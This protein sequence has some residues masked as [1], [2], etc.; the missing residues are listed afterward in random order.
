M[1][2]DKNR[3]TVSYPRVRE[4]RFRCQDF[5][6]ALIYCFLLSLKMDFFFSHP[7]EEEE[8][9]EEKERKKRREKEEEEKGRRKRRRCADLLRLC[10]LIQN[11][12]KFGRS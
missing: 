5:F 12:F 10:T 8:K 1:R 4:R 3:E 6:H 2:V 9:E 7:Q 11:F